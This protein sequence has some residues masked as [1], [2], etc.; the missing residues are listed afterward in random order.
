MAEN[1]NYMTLCPHCDAYLPART[2]RGHRET[3][4]DSI[5]KSWHKDPNLVQSSDEESAFIEID[6]SISH[7][8]S[9]SGSQ[10]ESDCNN[11]LFNESLLDHE[12]WD[13]ILDHEVDEDTAE[14]PNIPFVDAD[15]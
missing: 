1:N 11:D 5:T 15:T 14:N 2:F 3:F 9:S 6:D 8:S 7:R 10:D 13:N 4:F 12:I